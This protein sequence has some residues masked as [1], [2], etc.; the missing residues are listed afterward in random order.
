MAVSTYI[1]FMEIFLSFYQQFKINILRLLY[2]IHVYQYCPY[3]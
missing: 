1:F 3:T 2:Y